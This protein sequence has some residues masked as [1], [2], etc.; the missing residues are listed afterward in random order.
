MKPNN[1]PPVLVSIKTRIFDPLGFEIRNLVTCPESSAYE[2]CSF[3]IN[4]SKIVF[5][6]AKITPAK[7]GQFVTIWKRNEQG[8]T[9]PYKVSDD[10]DC[11]VI[12]V[13]SG[14]HSG[15]FILS[16][17]ALL[18]H[19]IID[20]GIQ[21]GKRGFRVYPPW[22]VT[23]NNQARK[24]QKWQLEY[25]IDTSGANVDLEKIKNLFGW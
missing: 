3:E 17:T 4:A 25:F 12:H 10:F 15:Q 13:A 9:R 7:T 2:G 8:I 21:S 14:K 23:N 19:G 20:D 6:T 18:R 1:F 16:K 24:A 11:M 22:D 5:R